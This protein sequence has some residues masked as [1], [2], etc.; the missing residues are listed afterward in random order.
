[1]QGED[2]LYGTVLDYFQHEELHFTSLLTQAW[3]S[4]RSRLAENTKMG[5]MVVY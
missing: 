2:F 3:Q 5:E 1:V 4:K